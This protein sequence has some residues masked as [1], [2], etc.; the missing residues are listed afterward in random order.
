MMRSAFGPMLGRAARSTPWMA[1]ELGE[2]RDACVAGAV[3]RG[4][5]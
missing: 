4:S 3:W 1:G 5:R 2:G